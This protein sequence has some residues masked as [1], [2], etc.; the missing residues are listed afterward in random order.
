M[1]NDTALESR[2]GIAV[3]ILRDKAGVTQSRL[4]RAT[5]VDHSTISRLEAGEQL[6]PVT[7]LQALLR[8]FKL[9]VNTF[10]ASFGLSKVEYEQDRSKKYPHQ[11][12]ANRLKV[13]ANSIKGINAWLGNDVVI[14]KPGRPA[15]LPAPDEL[16]AYISQ[17]FASARHA[18]T[19]YPAHRLA[20]NGAVVQPR[21]GV[22]PSMSLL[23]LQSLTQGYFGKAPRITGMYGLSQKTCPIEIFTEL[24]EPVIARDDESAML[25]TTILSNY[26]QTYDAFEQQMED[27]TWHYLDIVPKTAIQRL[28]RLRKLPPD[29][30]ITYLGV[31]DLSPRMVK[32][33]L[34][35][36]VI[37][38]WSYPDTYHLVLLDVISDPTD[39]IVKILARHLTEHF[40]TIKP[41]ADGQLSLIVTE[42]PVDNDGQR[43]EVTGTLII[44]T[45][46][47][48]SWV[49]FVICVGICLLTTW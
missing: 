44:R 31:D 27:K 29:S 49:Y 30:S 46:S 7:T 3:R 4:A 48:R 20:R 22:N 38:L 21:D 8:F 6:P 25:A 9:D 33:L 11:D 13:P 37:L 45:L 40:W 18:A 5:N 41:G 47:K 15:A 23:F 2:I 17:Q 39:G 26:Q 1:E 12:I 19:V 32:R 14:R 43:R 24:A 35:N 34:K 28:V 16:S 10:L 42:W 36:V